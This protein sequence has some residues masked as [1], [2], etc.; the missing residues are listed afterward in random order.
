M[1]DSVRAHTGRHTHLCRFF[2]ERACRCDQKR[3]RSPGLTGATAEAL[4][5]QGVLASAPREFLGRVT[6]AP[7]RRRGGPLT[8][9]GGFVNV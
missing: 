9:Y 6:A 7:R 4:T 1:P 2:L 8:K 3:C 5:M